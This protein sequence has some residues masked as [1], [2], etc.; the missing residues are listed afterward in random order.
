MTPGSDKK[1]EQHVIHIDRNQY[2]VAA[3][4]LTGEALR[5]LP[6][7]PIGDDRDLFLEHAGE[8]DDQLVGRHDVIKLKNG[9][10]FFTA[11]TTIAPG[12]AA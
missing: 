7:P 3:D 2:K 8:A 12:C 4:E 6:T 5:A 9:M 11:P 10:H 1:T